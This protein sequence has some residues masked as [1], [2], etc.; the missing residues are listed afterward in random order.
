[1]R[2][3]ESN[4]TVRKISI[5]TEKEVL[6]MHKSAYCICKE[7]LGLLPKYCMTASC[8]LSSK[9][10]EQPFKGFLEQSKNMKFK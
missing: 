3:G 10:D 5:S 7:F 4:A 2:M 9:I 6:V 8:T 1:M